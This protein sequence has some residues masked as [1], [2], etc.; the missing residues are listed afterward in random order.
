[1]KSKITMLLLSLL[2]AL[3]L[4][5]YVISVVSPESE[6]TFYDIPVSYQN[7]ILEE[8]KRNGIPIVEVAI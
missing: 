4:W 7:D 5:Y 6:E 2:I 8:L 1:M 3:V